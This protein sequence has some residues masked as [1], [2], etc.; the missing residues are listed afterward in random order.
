MLFGPVEVGVLAAIPP[1]A[2]GKELRRCHIVEL[3]YTDL[4]QPWRDPRPTIAIC[5]PFLEPMTGRRP[6]QMARAG[7]GLRGGRG[8]GRP[9]TRQS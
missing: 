9:L 6:R 4:I 8:W 1:A 2:T 3:A 7:R 5:H